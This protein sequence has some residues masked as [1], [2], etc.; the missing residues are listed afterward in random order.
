MARSLVFPELTGEQ[1]VELQR[2]LRSRATP[3]GVQRRAQLIWELAAGASLVE[4]P[5][6]LTF[7]IQTRTSGLSGS[8]IPV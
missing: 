5:N 8:W 2:I 3:A 4:Q 7:T 1:L 6:G